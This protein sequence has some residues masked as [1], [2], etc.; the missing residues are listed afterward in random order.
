[1]VSVPRATELAAIVALMVTSEE[2]SNEAEPLKSPP[3]EIARDAARAV[4]VDAFPT[5]GAVTAA[6]VTEEDVPTA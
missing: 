3:K 6:N 4:A 5:S 1:M 2:P